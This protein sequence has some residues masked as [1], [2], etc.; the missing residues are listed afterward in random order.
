MDAERERAEDAVAQRLLLLRLRQA[1]HQDGQDH[2]VVGAEQAFER[3]EQGDGDEVGRLDVQD[4][5]SSI[6]TSRQ[7]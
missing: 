1:E 3:D 7:R 2:R 4:V 5:A 6:R